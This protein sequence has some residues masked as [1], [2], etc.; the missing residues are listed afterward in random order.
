MAPHAQRI[1]VIQ[2]ASR[3]PCISAIRYAL[4][5]L[6]LNPGDI[7]ELHGILQPFKTQKTGCSPGCMPIK[8][9]SSHT[10]NK[11]H[12]KLEKE[13]QEKLDEFMNY[14]EMI[15]LHRVA[16]MQ[17]VELKVS[18]EAGILKEVGTQYAKSIQ[19][20]TVILDR[21]LK[22]D[23]NYFADKLSCG[24]LRMKQGNEIDCIKEK[25]IDEVEKNSLEMSQSSHTSQESCKLK[26]DQQ[27]QQLM[28]ESSICSICMYKRPQIGNL[29][30]FNFSQLQYATDRFSPHNELTCFGKKIYYMGVLS[31][32]QFIMVREHA[33]RTIK[34]DEFKSQVKMMET[35]RHENVATL[36]GSCS[37]EHHR[38]LVYEYVCNGSLETLL[39][40]QSNDLTWERRMKIAYRVAK[41][42][43]YLHL[44]NI[45]GNVR[46]NNIMV[47]HD[48]HPMLA[49]F[50]L[51]K[52][53]YEGVDYSSTYER[54]VLKTFEYLAPEYEER[55]IDWSKADVY[56]FGVVLL[57]LI[58]GRKTMEDT[59]GQS[60]LRWA[61]PLMRQKKYHELL[62][63]TIDNCHDIYQ[64]HCLLRVADKCLSWDPENRLSIDKVVRA[65]A[66]ISHGCVIR[67]F[68]PTESEMKDCKL[69][70]V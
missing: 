64:L 24:I 21:V 29:V 59:N 16:K 14:S 3:E 23:Q 30:D 49:S 63:S 52:N 22:K 27:L 2:E 41:G 56:S 37:E 66:C 9:D 40:N 4:L 20:T 57:E 58:T 48:F 11:K 19:A 69:L 10:L 8:L 1:L 67:D 7:I 35:I 51:V 54:R 18:V 26:Q 38:L 68:S 13:I 47:T 46:P 70:R 39:S 32:G 25:R 12:E 50:G 6:S 53:R 44:N 45:Y 17:Q 28:A 43:K 60:F 61:R 34:L 55:G 5:E 62:D 33:S 36:I 31:D 65:L 42:L 15:R